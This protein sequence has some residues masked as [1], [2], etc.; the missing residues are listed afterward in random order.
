MGAV[1]FCCSV[2]QFHQLFALL[3]DVLEQDRASEILVRSKSCYRVSFSDFHDRTQLSH[4]IGCPLILIS[5]FAMC[6]FDV[7]VPGLD[8]TV[9]GAYICA[10]LFTVWYTAWGIS[11]KGVERIALLGVCA[12]FALSVRS[13]CVAHCSSFQFPDCISGTTV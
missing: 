1:V 4:H 5:L 8:V 7:T 10:T 6:A 2:H 3:P 9:N 12:V 11:G 13:T